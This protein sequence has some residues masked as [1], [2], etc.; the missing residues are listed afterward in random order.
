MSEAT[1]WLKLS[2]SPLMSNDNVGLE[3]S[4]REAKE[5]NGQIVATSE[6]GLS[7]SEELN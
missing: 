5:S 2:S 6:A 4:V 3:W 1:D 7:P